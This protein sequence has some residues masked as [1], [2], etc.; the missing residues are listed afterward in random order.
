MLNVLS[1]CS[2]IG[3]IELGLK[4]TGGFR[5]VC[6]VEKDPYCVAVLISRIRD[7]LLDDA[8]IHGD[9]KTFDAGAWRGVVDCVTAGFPC[10]PVSVAGKGLGEADP[11][12]LWPDII[13]IVRQVR[14]RLVLLE[15]VPGLLVHGMGRVIGDLAESGYDCQWDRISAAAVGA[16]HLRRRI[17]IVG[18]ASELGCC[19]EPRRRAGSELADGCSEMADSDWW[20]V[21]PDVGR[22]AH[23]VPHRVDRLRAL[24]NAVVPQV[25]EAV[26]RLI[27]SWDGTRRL[28]AAEGEEARTEIRVWALAGPRT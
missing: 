1:L 13:G 25:A 5:T 2:G 21:E 28:W 15:N 18:Y 10:Q 3:G 14:P 7:G 26:G 6:Y 20:A 4:R 27:S 22:V 17:F 24:G 9:L 12:W 16:N 19:G 8:P 23:G 11:R